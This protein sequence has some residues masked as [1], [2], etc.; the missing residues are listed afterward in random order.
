MLCRELLAGLSS[1]CG[2]YIEIVSAL[3]SN[4]LQ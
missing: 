1:D 3:G 2:E 4:L